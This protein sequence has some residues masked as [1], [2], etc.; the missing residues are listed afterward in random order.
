MDEMNRGKNIG[1]GKDTTNGM[2]VNNEYVA[3]KGKYEIM[4]KME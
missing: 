3:T 1:I 4:Q 2:N